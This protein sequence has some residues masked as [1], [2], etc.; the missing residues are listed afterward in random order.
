MFFI[1]VDSLLRDDALAQVRMPAAKNLNSWSVTRTCP[2]RLTRVSRAGIATNT[3][4]KM[5]K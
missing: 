2:R 3:V 4:S 1:M 5:Q